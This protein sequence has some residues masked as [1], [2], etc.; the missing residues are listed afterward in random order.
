[1]S[2]INKVTHLWYVGQQVVQ[3]TRIVWRRVLQE[4]PQYLNVTF[5]DAL[6]FHFW[7]IKQMNNE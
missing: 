6:Q 5:L 3:S 7:R 4:T 1:M 2:R